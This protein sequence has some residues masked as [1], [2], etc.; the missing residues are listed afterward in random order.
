MVRCTSTRTH[1]S[2]ESAQ[3]TGKFAI[4]TEDCVDDLYSVRLCLRKSVCAVFYQIMPHGG[5]GAAGALRVSLLTVLSF[6]AVMGSGPICV[7]GQMPSAISG[8]F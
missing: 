8:M 1:I 7:P 5:F 6:G 2:V 4:R 3:F